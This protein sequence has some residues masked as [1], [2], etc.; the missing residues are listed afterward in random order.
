MKEIPEEIADIITMLEAKQVL[1]GCGHELLV[2]KMS[3]DEAL[4]TYHNLHEK[5]RKDHVK[6]S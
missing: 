5:L 3:R 1:R 4:Q 2:G 6:E